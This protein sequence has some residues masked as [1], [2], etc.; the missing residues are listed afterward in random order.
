MTASPSVAAPRP[1]L[2]L[3]DASFTI[4]TIMKELLDDER[5]HATVSPIL[6]ES[7]AE[8]AA[9][10]PALLIID[11]GFEER[12]GWELLEQLARETVTRGIPVL[13]T[14]T[15]QRL[16]DGA[17]ANQGQYG[18]ESW[19]VKLFEIERIMSEVRRLTATA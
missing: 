5:C 13:V 17:E 8:I 15:D 9:G 18:G 3:F 14:S 10:Q 12:L 6:P 2:M 11:L 7:F 4:R 16:L 1:H 19:V